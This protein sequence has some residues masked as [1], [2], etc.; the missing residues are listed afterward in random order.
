MCTEYA[1]TSE[2]KS[3]LPTG[4]PVGRLPGELLLQM[5][6]L[7]RTLFP[8]PRWAVCVRVTRRSSLAVG[9]LES[10]SFTH[11]KV[12][13]SIFGKG[14]VCSTL[15]AVWTESFKWCE[16]LGSMHLGCQEGAPHPPTPTSALLR[17]ARP[18]WVF[19][20]WK[21]KQETWGFD[22]EIV[23]C[24]HSRLPGKLQMRNQTRKLAVPSVLS[25]P[26]KHQ[27]EDRKA[28]HPLRGN[29]FDLASAHGGIDFK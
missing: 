25:Q 1:G 14:F 21:L 11:Y 13:L 19:G 27:S 28:V 17:G 7:W 15:L 5:Q 4:M 9:P 12:F 18:T 29:F 8:P 22:A 3:A 10:G 26:P 20:T 24:P 6:M 23:V 16:V 2:C